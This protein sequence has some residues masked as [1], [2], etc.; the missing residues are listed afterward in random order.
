MIS[1]IGLWDPERHNWA[2]LHARGSAIH[3]P[4]TILKLAG[5]ANEE[6][7]DRY[8]WQ[9]DGVVIFQGAL[10]EAVIPTITAMVLVLPHASQ[11]G[12]S[13]ILEFLSQAANGCWSGEELAKGLPDQS[14][15][16]HQETVRGAYYYLALLP[17][18]GERELGWCVDL[19]VYCAVWEP[20]LRPIVFWHIERLLQDYKGPT[21]S[22]I[23]KRLRYA[24]AVI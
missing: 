5:A 21:R 2:S 14:A 16:C 22:Y 7:A 20:E 23:E 1:G 19:L 10:Y 18:A 15:R 4:A 24:K 6:E 3:V 8:Y 17:V 12:R 11:I 13:Q 9:I